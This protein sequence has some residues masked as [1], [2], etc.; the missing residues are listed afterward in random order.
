VTFRE[1]FVIAW[2][3]VSRATSLRGWWTRW[4]GNEG[5]RLAS[6]HLRRLGYRIVARQYRNQWGEIDLIALDGDCVVFVEV[7]TRRA[8]VPGHPIDAVTPAKQAKLTRLALG[9]QKK[10]RLLDRPARFDVVTVMRPDDGG[11]PVVEHFRNAFPPVGRGQM[12]S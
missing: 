5:E 7:K 2:R 12:F 3:P 8:G 4:L 11:R 9:F 10:K 6:R 1:L